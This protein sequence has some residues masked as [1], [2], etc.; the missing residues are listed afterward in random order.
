MKNCAGDGN[1][2]QYCTGHTIT[3]TSPGRGGGT[4]WARSDSVNGWLPGPGG[5]TRLCRL[6]IFSF[7]N[8]VMIERNVALFK[9]T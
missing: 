3:G 8:T 2:V 1:E 7:I 9:L 6:K 4:M 5:L